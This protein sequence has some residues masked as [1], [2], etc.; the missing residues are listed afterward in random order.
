MFL[1][2]AYARA[3]K[4]PFSRAFLVYK[5]KKMFYLMRAMRFFPGMYYKMK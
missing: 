5:D 2:W 1:L 3:I 4:M